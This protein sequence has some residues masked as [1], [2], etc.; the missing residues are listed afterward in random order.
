MI[1]RPHFPRTARDPSRWDSMSV[2]FRCKSCGQ[3]VQNKTGSGPCRTGRVWPG[4]LSWQREATPL[5]QKYS[6]WC[7]FHD[8]DLPQRSSAAVGWRGVPFPISSGKDSFTPHL[9]QMADHPPVSFMGLPSSLPLHHRTLK[10]GSQI[11]MGIST[12][13]VGRVGGTSDAIGI[14]NVN[15]HIGGPKKHR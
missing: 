5:L 1:A 11:R 7:C 10:C 4:S 12:R 3:E 8:T 13:N 6:H 14:S 15:K 9:L 2:P